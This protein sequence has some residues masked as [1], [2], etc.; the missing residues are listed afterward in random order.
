MQGCLRIIKEGKVEIDKVSDEVEAVLQKGGVVVL[1]T[2]TIYGL[3][4]LA[5]KPEAVE[6]IYELK[7]RSRDKPLIVLI[8]EM[9][10]LN[11]F[12]VE[13]DDGLRKYLN[14]VWPGRVSVIL[15]CEGSGCE[16]LH[17]GLDSIAFRVPAR[18]DLL[19]LLERVGPLVS[20]SVN[21]EG[22]R[23]AVGVKEARLYFGDR[24]DLYVDGGILDGVASRVVRYKGGGKIEILRG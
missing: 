22:E 14:R 21:V 13:I 16:Y 19:R 10:D 1:P 2:D 18:A 8:G 20:S 15:D 9:G 3:H 11:R 12:G 24:V 23:A 6:K 5:M 17:R 4:A 7:H